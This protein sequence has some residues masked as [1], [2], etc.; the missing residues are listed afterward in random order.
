MVNTWM[1]QIE[2]QVPCCA[3]GSFIPSFRLLLSNV[4]LFINDIIGAT[5]IQRAL[6]VIHCPLKCRLC[7]TI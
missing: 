5:L 3:G 1:D 6:F 2:Q 7:Q 4:A